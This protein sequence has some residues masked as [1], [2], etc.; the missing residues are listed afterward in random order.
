MG[1]FLMPKQGVPW[2]GRNSYIGIE[3]EPSWF[4]Q[5]LS[6]VRWGKLKKRTSPMRIHRAVTRRS[7][8]LWSPRSLWMPRCRYGPCGRGAIR[9]VGGQWVVRS[10]LALTPHKSQGDSDR[11]FG[12]YQPTQSAIISRNN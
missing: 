4:N 8:C 3:L 2:Y 9:Q 6:D 10:N 12:L 7:H 5:A 11:L 1:E